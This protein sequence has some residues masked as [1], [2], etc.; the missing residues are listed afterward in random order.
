MVG[1]VFAIAI[2]LAMWSVLNP[3]KDE[4][5]TGA[6][7]AVDETGQLGEAYD[8]YKSVPNPKAQAEQGIGARLFKLLNDDPYKFMAVVVIAAA[9]LFVFGVRLKTMR[10]Y[11][12]GL[13]R[14]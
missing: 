9:I 4:A 2:L 12:R 13:T 10:R 1:I 7:T 14:W 5:I 8:A 6:V 3:A 11:Q